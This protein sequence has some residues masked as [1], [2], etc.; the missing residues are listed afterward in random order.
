[1]SEV[2][3]FLFLFLLL[4]INQHFSLLILC[5][6][7]LLFKLFDLCLAFFFFSLKHKVFLVDSVG[8]LQDNWVFKF[9]NLY[10]SFLVLNRP[11]NLYFIHGLLKT[12][13]KLN[14]FLFGFNL[15]WKLLKILLFELLL[16]KLLLLFSQLT[17]LIL[18]ISQ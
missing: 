13:L 16:N 15:F 3:L 12:P 7:Y 9:L 17:L 18:F 8:S 1:M 11:L 6:L 4:V 5:F 2:P 14:G 10:C